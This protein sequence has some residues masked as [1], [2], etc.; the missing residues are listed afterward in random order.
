MMSED[1]KWIEQNWKWSNKTFPHTLCVVSTSDETI[2]CGI[3]L[4]SN[5]NLHWTSGGGE[6]GPKIAFFGTIF[7]LKIGTLLAK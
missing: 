7:S 1:I 2:P 4:T 5:K 3:C 6:F